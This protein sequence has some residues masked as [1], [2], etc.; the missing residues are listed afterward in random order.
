MTMIAG[1]G[2]AGRMAEMQVVEGG[3]HVAEEPAITPEM[4]ANE[5]EWQV[6]AAGGQSA[7]SEMVAAHAASRPEM[8]G[9]ISNQALAHAGFGIPL[10][11][12]SGLQE[13][14]AGLRANPFDA[15]AV[16]SLQMAVAKETERAA[17]VGALDLPAG[18]KNTHGSSALAAPLQKDKHALAALQA[19]ADLG[20]EAAREMMAHGMTKEQLFAQS[21][22]LAKVYASDPAF[23]V[24][25]DAYVDEATSPHG[26]LSAIHAR[27]DQE[28]IANHRALAN[29]YFPA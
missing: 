19:N 2:R 27:L 21:P 18:Y 29:M 12:D 25:F 17:L 24:G 13:A 9:A 26:D 14:I 8:Y 3:P 6:D 5:R 1:A 23:H 16:V 22:D 10:A 15:R 28:S 7:R 4:A 20:M 11:G